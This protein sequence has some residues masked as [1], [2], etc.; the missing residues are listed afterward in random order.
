MHSSVYLEKKSNLLA[1]LVVKMVSN[2]FLF[3]ALSR[4]LEIYV[5]SVP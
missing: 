1:I 5:L 4:P 2:F 3:L